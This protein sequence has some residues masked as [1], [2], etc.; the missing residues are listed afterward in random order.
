[1]PA[2]P[3]RYLNCVVFLYKSRERAKQGNVA[4]GGTGFLLTHEG[5]QYV[6]TNWHCARHLPTIRLST[7]AG[8]DYITPRQGQWLEHL[9]GDDLAA[10]QVELGS[11][12]DHL[13][14]IS[15]RSAVWDSATT[16]YIQPGGDVFFAGRYV[17]HSG[18]WTNTP[19]I[20][21][22]NIAMMPTEPITNSLGSRQDSFLVEARSRVGFS[23]SPV[24][25]YRMEIANQMTTSLH[26]PDTKAKAAE[27]VLLGAVWG[28]LHDWQP[29]HLEDKRSILEPR[30]YVDVNSNIACV[31]PSWKIRELLDRQEFQDMREQRRK[32]LAESAAVTDFASDGEDSDL[33]QMTDLTRKLL[34]VPKSEVDEVHREHQ[35]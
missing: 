7:P 29:V 28:H 15:M 31:V 18:V 22:G 6:I 10:Y 30:Q 34:Q 13:H 14:A 21:F 26:F 24:F 5:A 4:E 25:A 2:I 32:H 8:L 33:D 23:G 17:T 9:A 1:M 3:D 16:D 12:L 11:S 20:R 35:Q 19:M 27:I